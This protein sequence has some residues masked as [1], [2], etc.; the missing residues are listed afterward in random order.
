MPLP[1]ILLT[2]D[3]GFESE[4][5]HRLCETLAAI[6]QVVVVAPQDA[7]SGAGT[8]IGDPTRVRARQFTMTG[9][10]SAW[11]LDANPGA[12]VLLARFGAFGPPPDLLVSGINQGF[13][14]GRQAC[15]SG[16]VGAALLGQAGGIP[17][18]AVSQDDANAYDKAPGEQH[19]RSAAE[20]AL[21]FA[22]LLLE[23]NAGMPATLNLNVPNLALP[24][25]V[26]WR[27]TNLNPELPR[28]GMSA[29]VAMPDDGDGWIEFDFGR[30]A[31]P[32]PGTDA[33]AVEQ[34]YVSATWLAALDQGEGR[35]SGVDLAGLQFPA[36]AFAD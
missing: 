14:L 23:R 25:I 31:A 22:K 8:A 30:K 9:A 26:G 18:L 33:H 35:H 19:W 11:A 15:H 4:G 27:L 24:D 7:R 17:S 5:L 36:P 10:A 3:D 20:V 2:N 12:C 16:T 28:E 29:R 21:A 34:G 6:G 13:N 32:S 1:R